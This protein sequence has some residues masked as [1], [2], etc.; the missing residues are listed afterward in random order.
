MQLRNISLDDLSLYESFYCEPQM[1][2]HLGGAWDRELMPDKLRRDVEKVESDRA[3]VFKIIPDEDSS[4]AAGTVCLWENSWRGE[5]ISEI[6][7]MILPQ[8]QRQ[9][10]GTKAVRAILDKA[11]AEKRWGEVIH[12]FPSITNAPSN[13]ICLK[14]GFS[15]IEECDLEYAGQMLRCNHW[16]LD[17][18]SLPSNAA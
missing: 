16:R 6:G 11:R 12:A 15:L 7:W 4:N 1:M 13:A 14:M 2:A 9:G 18:R 8:F 10:L 17:M 5:S 3:W